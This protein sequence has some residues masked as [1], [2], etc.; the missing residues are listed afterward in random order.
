MTAARAAQGPLAGGAEVAAVLHPDVLLSRPAAEVLRL[1]YRGWTAELRGNTV[2]VPEQIWTKGS[3]PADLVRCLA[4]AQSYAPREVKSARQQGR[5][6]EPSP[7]D[8]QR[9]AADVLRDAAAIAAKDWD[10]R[11]CDIY[12][13]LRRAWANHDHVVAYTTLTLPLRHMVEHGNLLNY[14]DTHLRA[15]I[16][17]LFRRAADLTDRRRCAQ[18]L[19]GAGPRTAHRSIKGKGNAPATNR[20]AS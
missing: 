18:I 8:P 1:R 6:L 3:D 5:P 19:P 12:T 9:V 7:R 16:S 2:V 13:C 17:A 15:D 4:I 14:N 11:Y 10:R 20:A